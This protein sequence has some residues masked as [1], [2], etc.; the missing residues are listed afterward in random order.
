MSKSSNE[1]Q[2]QN[3]QTNDKSVQTNMYA[4]KTLGGVS[5]TKNVQRRSEGRGLSVTK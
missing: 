1:K 5:H 4:D 3:N 2:S